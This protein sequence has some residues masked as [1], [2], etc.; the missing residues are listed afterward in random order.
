MALAIYSDGKGGGCA[1]LCSSVV[2]GLPLLDSK[3]EVI[4]VSPIYFHLIFYPHLTRAISLPT[5]QVRYVNA[6]SRPFLPI[7]KGVLSLI[8]F[9][10]SSLSITLYTITS[11]S[12][13]NTSLSRIETATRN[14]VVAA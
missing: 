4:K 14:R 3:W 1:F 10:F 5:K 9:F 8:L 11:S 7:N 6:N 12:N 2:I 13:A